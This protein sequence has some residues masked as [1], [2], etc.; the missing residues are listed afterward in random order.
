MYFAYYVINR[1][2]IRRRTNSFWVTTFKKI[3]LMY[4]ST[5]FDIKYEKRH[6][7][8]CECLTYGMNLAD[9]TYHDLI[10]DDK[11]SLTSAIDSV[12]SRRLYPG[13]L[14]IMR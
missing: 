10:F 6:F 3:N 1:I 4:F 13:W 7:M 11:I 14:I 12:R 5:K 8:S 2:D 9:R